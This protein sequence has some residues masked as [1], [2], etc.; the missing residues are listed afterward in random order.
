MCLFSHAI[1]AQPFDVLIH[2]HKKVALLK[3]LIQ[4]HKKHIINLKSHG[5][6]MNDKLHKNKPSPNLA[7]L[8][9]AFTLHEFSIVVAVL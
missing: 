8:W 3:N 5:K 6:R 9:F 4:Q 2:P 7:R 1:K